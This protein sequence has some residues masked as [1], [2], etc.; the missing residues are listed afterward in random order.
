MKAGVLL[1]LETQRRQYDG[2]NIPL[3]YHIRWAV[4]SVIAKGCIVTWVMPLKY[5]LPLLLNY[6]CVYVIIMQ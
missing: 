5:V 1:T 6:I 4:V 3:G 2:H